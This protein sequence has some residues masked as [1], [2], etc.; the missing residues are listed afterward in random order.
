MAVSLNRNGLHFK[1]ITF[2]NLMDHDRFLSNLHKYFEIK[3][4]TGLTFEGD[5]G[6]EVACG[7]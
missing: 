3:G 4:I 5:S 2:K 7:G 1:K 6:E